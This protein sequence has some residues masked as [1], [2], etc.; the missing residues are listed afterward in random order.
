MGE[1]KQLKIIGYK[2]ETF[3]A[4]TGHSFS[5]MVNPGNYSD[6]KGIR[7]HQDKNAMEG[8]NAP[9]Y[10]GYNDEKLHFEFILDTTG[11]LIDWKDISGLTDRKP[12]SELVESLEKTVYTYVDS[13]H[14]PPFLKVIWGGLS[15]KGRLKKLNVEYSLFNSE[16]QPL[17]AKVKLDIIK[18][19]D[20]KTQNKMKN[21]SSPD[22]SHLVTLRAGDT[23]P[24]LCMQVYQSAAYCTEVARI[25]HLTG[26]RDIVPGMQLF[27]PPLA[28]E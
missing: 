22:L 20:Q 16:A 10:K 19:V 11:V 17:R 1:L 2:D 26:F 23:L 9:T 12:L 4:P 21:K 18:F 25:N 27:F 13:Q 28:D 15:Y 24:M 8:G 14:Q 7:Y 5:T 3:S 6:D